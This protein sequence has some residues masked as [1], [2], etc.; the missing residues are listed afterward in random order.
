MIIYG[1][2]FHEKL[3]GVAI[4]RDYLKY[5]TPFCDLVD[6]PEWQVDIDL[7]LNYHKA[8]YGNLDAANKFVQDLTL[9][10]NTLD[11]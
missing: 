1:N 10:S 2:N 6:S 5:N 8:S 11:W 3:Q 7:A 4:S 9:N